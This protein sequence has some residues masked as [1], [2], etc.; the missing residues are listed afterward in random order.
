MS[1]TDE[2]LREFAEKWGWLIHPTF[3]SPVY[4]KDACLEELNVLL[5]KLKQDDEPKIRVVYVT[6]LNGPQETILELRELLR[7]T[8]RFKVLSLEWLNKTEN[9]DI[10]PLS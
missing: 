1:K 2:L 7:F 5:D 10:S 9:A 6:E 3:G 8:R 4:K